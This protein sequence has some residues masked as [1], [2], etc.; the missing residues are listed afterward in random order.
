MRLEIRYPDRPPH[1]VELTGAI[2]VLGR[3]PSCD[4]VIG[5][6]R[7]SRK[8][9]VLELTP[10]GLQVR[11]AGSANGVFVNG[12]KLERSL[13]T[14]GDLVRLGDV[15][16]KV[17][18][19][20]MPGT[21]VVAG[22]LAE[23]GPA[24]TGSV[25]PSGPSALDSHDRHRIG[26]AQPPSAAPRAR[27]PPTGP[28]S[29]AGAPPAKPPSS[30]STRPRTSPGSK[31]AERPSPASASAPTAGGGR[32]LTVTLLAALW[33]VSILV[34]AAQAAVSFTLG[35]SRG[36]AI[37]AAL[38]S[39]V[40]AL[41]SG[42]MAF[43]LFGLKPWARTAQTVIAALGLV[44]CPFTLASA[45]TLIYVLRPSTKAA[46][47]PGARPPADPAEMTF[48]LTLVGTVVLGAALFVAGL[49]VASRFLR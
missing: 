42:A 3:D 44:V 49:F 47:T 48:A 27:K 8:H 17:L 39:I 25:A 13:L 21:V 5:D 43:G 30:A 19:E 10:T 20:E 36:E 18:P 46:F 11:D 7:C 32:P 28:L 4:L 40:L 45:T 6:E 22:E 31:G 1:E 9:A 12:K 33:L 38:V 16:L 35:L 23:L 26:S 14:P 37:A 29:G 24:P 15:I 2:A 34:Y 41:L